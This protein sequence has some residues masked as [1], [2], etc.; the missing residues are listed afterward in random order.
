MCYATGLT[1]ALNLGSNPIRALHSLTAAQAASITAA[2]SRQPIACM[3]DEQEGYDGDL[4]LVLT[5]A[6]PYNELSFALW[7]SPAGFHLV[8]IREDEQV[9]SEILASLEDVLE[10]VFGTTS[11]VRH[12]A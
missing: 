3:A 7:R 2:L 6:D 10:T 9:G 4:T 12:R 8:T 5:P 11:P 1:S